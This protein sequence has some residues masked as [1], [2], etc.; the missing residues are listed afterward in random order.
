MPWPIV[1]PQSLT[2]SRFTHPDIYTSSMGNRGA[3]CDFSLENANPFL[4]AYKVRERYEGCMEPPITSASPH[5]FRDIYSMLLKVWS[6]TSL[7]V[8]TREEGFYLTAPHPGLG[9]SISRTFNSSCY[10][11]P[12]NLAEIDRLAV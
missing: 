12:K 2:Q 7:L 5:F 11:M 8:R 4:V 10:D 9:T 3:F 6:G 1:C